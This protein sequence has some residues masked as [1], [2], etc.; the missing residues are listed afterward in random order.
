MLASR[1][2]RAASRSAS[3]LF[4][5]GLSSSRATAAPSF[6]RMSGA[7]NFSSTPKQGSK[8]LMCLYEGGEHAKQ[9]PGLLGCKENELGLRKWLEDQGHTLVTTSDK[10]GPNSEFD[11]HLV[12]A[13]VVITTP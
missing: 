1:F 11:K 5:G 7:R 13:E 6:T 8:V 12:D 3:S 4:A 2:G 9:Q 10:E